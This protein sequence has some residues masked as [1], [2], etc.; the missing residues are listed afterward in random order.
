VLVLKQCRSG[1]IVPFYG[2][3]EIL[4]LDGI[5]SKKVK[6]VESILNIQHNCHNGGCEVT[7]SS[8]QR[9]ERKDVGGTTSIISH[10][11]SNSYILNTA[12]H[13]SAELHRRLSKI[14]LANVSSDQ[15]NHAI[16][17]GVKNWKS[18]PKQASKKARLSK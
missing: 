18:M 16:E 4:L 8:G 11:N 14:E 9:V 10:N 13:Y 15:W 5:M 7:D 2:M 1:Q 17:K 12:S 6:D 3:R